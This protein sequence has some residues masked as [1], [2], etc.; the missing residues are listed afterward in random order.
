MPSIHSRW[1]SMQS[2]WN[3]LGHLFLL[4]GTNGPFEP[5]IP[6]HT[7]ISLYKHTLDLTTSESTFSVPSVSSSESEDGRDASDKEKSELMQ[8]SSSCVYLD[9]D[10]EGRCVKYAMMPMLVEE[11]E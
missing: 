5:F 7:Y 9:C 4:Q 8:S 2:K 6:S 3:V 10:C 1:S 11:F